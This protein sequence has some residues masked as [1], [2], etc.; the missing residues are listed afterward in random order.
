MNRSIR[1]VLFIFISF[2]GVFAATKDRQLQTLKEE[3]TRAYKVLGKVQP[4]PAY[5]LQYE[6][7][8]KREVYLNSSIGA[9]FFDYDQNNAYVDIDV[10]VGS[11]RLD[12]T[13]EIRGND[14]FDYASWIPKTM[15]VPV[16]QNPDGLKALLWIETDRTFKDAQERYTKIQAERQVK[17]T[18]TDTSPDFSS[19]PAVKYNEETKEI[20]IDLEYWCQRLNTLSMRFKAH[21]WIYSSAVSLRAN[22]ETRCI[23]NTD[24]T[25]I[26]ESR[27]AYRFSIYA[28]TMADDG[29]DL[30]LSQSFIAYTP[31]KLPDDMTITA[32]I[33]TLIERLSALRN[34]PLV[35]PYIGPAILLNRAS[36]VFF[37]EIFGHRIEGHRQKS[38]FEGQTFTRKVNEQILPEFISVYDDPTMQVFN[39][40]D[41]NGH[42]RYDDEG[43][44]AQKVVVVER[45]VLKNFL[46]SR[47]PIK[48][49]PISNGHG[50]R[51]HGRNVVSRQGVLYIKSDKETSFDNLRQ[52][53][54]EECKKQN[55]E[56]GLIFYDISGGFTQTGRGGTQTFKVI[57]LF[58]ERIY[59]D[60]RPDEVVRGVDIVGTPLLSFSKIVLTGDDYDVFNGTC[61]AESGWVPVSAI[62]PSIFVSEI[63]VEKKAKGQEK[64]P[65]L[66]APENQHNH[67]R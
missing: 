60:G 23:V 43:V 14:D 33:D 2:S 18:E 57:P 29:M 15:E 12:N 21:S 26:K 36:G 22:S 11:A 7:W 42:F 27:L 25:M 19:A 10:R 51:E 37:H 52:A 58:V 39:N 54:I 55:K 64:P 49:F 30:Y 45:G 34:A 32:E 47:S 50:R 16:D 3:L 67:G 38:E 5:F 13:H 63:E 46:L 28:A 9:I 53:L 59:V 62:S 61:G 44:A 41:L 66:P 40:K 1:V 17:V 8:Q 65:I 48:N 35:E 56:Y 24:G 6:L 20:N 31:E 4:V